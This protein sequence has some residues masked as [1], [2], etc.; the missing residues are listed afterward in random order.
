M[1]GAHK[2]GAA[3]S[4]PRIAG[5]KI[6][7]MSFFLFLLQMCKTPLTLQS[8]PCFFDKKNKGEPQ[9]RSPGFSV[10]F[11]EPPKSLESD[12]K[13]APGARVN[14]STENLKKPQGNR[15]LQG[16]AGSGPKGVQA[17]IRNRLTHFSGTSNYQQNNDKIP[18]I[19]VEG[20][21]SSL[22]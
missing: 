22:V 16:L 21:T 19:V 17:P 1:P 12:R 8:A 3:I 5:G 6:T 20:C 7:D 2:F 10:N 14:S 11:A 18:S 15:K 13:N 9:K 4:G